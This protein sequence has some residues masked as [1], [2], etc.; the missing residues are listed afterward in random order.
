VFHI[1]VAKVDQDVAYV[2]KCFRDMLQVFQ[3]DVA[4][5]C[6]KYFICFRRMLKVFF[7]LMLHMFHAYVARVCSNYFSYFSLML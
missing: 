1:D 4:S 2:A 7:I 5:I 6:S 3:G